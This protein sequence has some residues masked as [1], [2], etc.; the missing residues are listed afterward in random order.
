MAGHHPPLTKC[1]A[2]ILSE[3]PPF[4][5]VLAAIDDSRCK[6]GYYPNSGKDGGYYETEGYEMDGY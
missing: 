4:A 3:R 2:R 1:V 6:P 5:P